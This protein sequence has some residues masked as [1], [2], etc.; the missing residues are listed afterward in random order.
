M[1]SNKINKKKIKK[2][3]PKGKQI[4]SPKGM[5]D[6][7]PEEAQARDKLYK[8][9]KDVLEFYGF[10]KI[11]T[12]IVENAELFSRTVGESTDIVEKE[13]YAVRS[14]GKEH[15][16]MRPE[17]T[18]SVV[19]SYLEHG[20]HRLP[21][22]QFLYY[23]G[24]AFRH[25]N[26]QAGRY[27]QFWQI[28]A[29][30]LG[31]ESDPIYDAQIIIAFSRLLGELKLKNLIVGINSIGGT[32]DRQNYKKKLLEHYRLHNKEI[33]KDCMRRMKTNPL[34]LLDCKSRSCQNIIDEAPSVLDHLSSPSKAHFK[35]V[36]EFLDEAGIPYVLKPRLVRGLDYYNKT[37]FEIFTEDDE[38][39]ELSLVGGGRYDYLAEI[40]GR[41]SV[42]GVGAAMGVERVLEAAKERDP[43]FGTPRSK[44]RVYLIHIGDLAKRKSISLLEEFREAHLPIIGN[45][46][47]TSLSNQLEAADK[48]G[49]TLALILG[50]KEVFEEDIIIR[51]MKTGAQETI[52][53]K[54]AVKEIKKRLK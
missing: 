32:A 2:S 12:P 34:R 38:K 46:G 36:L 21:Q 3:G 40:L 50:Q 43:S 41:R 47:K 8:V 18:A 30:V 35:S 19:R 44:K 27:R 4:L 54:K 26:P 11:E 16:V 45:L 6:V 39:G 53:L 20:L 5:H 51:D 25:E 9:A 1:P 15:L 49:A 52:P 24:P 17:M 13:M 28:G 14:R 48:A 10:G 42:A 29:E 22:P 7:L 37:V 33:C 31:G 23:I